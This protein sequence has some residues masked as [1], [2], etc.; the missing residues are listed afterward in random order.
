MRI[1]VIKLP[2]PL[3]KLLM[4]ILS[5]FGSSTGRSGGAS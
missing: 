3:G 4:A 1:A 5:I 2:K